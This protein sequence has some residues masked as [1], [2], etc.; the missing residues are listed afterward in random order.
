[1]LEF[2]A[3][4]PLELPTLELYMILFPK[5]VVTLPPASETKRCPAHISHSHD[6]PKAIMASNLPSATRANR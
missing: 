4:M 1:M 3:I 5:L 6:L 2:P